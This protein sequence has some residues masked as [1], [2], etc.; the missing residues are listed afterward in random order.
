MFNIVYICSLKIKVLP[1][2]FSGFLEV[3]LHFFRVFSLI[4]FMFFSG[5]LTFQTAGH[6]ALISPRPDLNRRRC[7]SVFCHGAQRLG[8]FNFLSGF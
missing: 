6:Y 2:I 7:P 5:F 8:F 3:G 1:E 4:F